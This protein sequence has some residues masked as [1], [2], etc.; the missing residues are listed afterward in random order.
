MKHINTQDHA[1][2]LKFSRFSPDILE[3]VEKY[4]VE[5][6]ESMDKQTELDFSEGQSANWCRFIYLK[7]P[8]LTHFQEHRKNK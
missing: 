3:L 5:G 1:S 8:L 4:R 7:H 6:E 2:G